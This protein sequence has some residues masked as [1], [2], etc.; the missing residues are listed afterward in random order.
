VSDHDSGCICG[1]KLV[2]GRVSGDICILR[3]VLKKG[4]WDCYI[5]DEG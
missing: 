2:T 4:P 3:T 1:V 5:L